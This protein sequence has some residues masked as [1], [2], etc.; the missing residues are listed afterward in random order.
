MNAF[1]AIVFASLLSRLGYQM[2]R[3]PVLP[4][5]AADL[6]ALPELIG[7]IVAASTVTVV[8]FKLPAGA[9]S[10][11][12][13]R[14]RMMVLGALFFAVPPFLYPFVGSPWW[15]LA[16]RFVHGFAT[17]IF[18]PVAAAYVA[19]LAETGRG[20]RLGW[21]SAGNDIG[22]T[23]GPLIGGFVLYFSASY[24]VTYLL[25][26]AIGV[27]TLLVVLWLPDVDRP[28]RE[29]RTFVSRAAEL[30]QGLAEVLRTPPILVAA[31]IEAVMYLGYGAFLGFLPIYAKTVGLND[32]EIAIVLGSQ[33]A[34]AMLAKPLT[35][36]LSDR[37][38][39]K[40]VIVIGLLL[41][42]LALP[43]I[44]RSASLATFIL[45][46]PLLGLG[47]GAVTPVTNALIADLASARRLGAAMGVFGTIWDI[48][49]AAGPII[50]GYL[51][52]SAGYAST[53]DTLALLTVAVSISVVFLVRDPKTAMAA[54]HPSARQ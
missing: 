23:A 38:G 41:C 47:V 3:S 11:V 26:G 20:A 43:L 6:G 13:G 24:A 49:E 46:A 36:R 52:G 40:P 44:F 16:L 18:S 32:A 37:A 54:Q 39:R 27:L 28:A 35:G 15:L 31:G 51:I 12:L 14:K 5:F 1:I 48:G 33:L 34:V 10:D 25:V 30:R 53:F 29:V 9:L 8:C 50:A 17:A 21:F 22:A 4:I 2:A 19:S 7:V 42:A 45:T